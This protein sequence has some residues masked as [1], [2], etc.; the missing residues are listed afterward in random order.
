M[1]FQS[2]SQ[3]V[4]QLV[5]P[6]ATYVIACVQVHDMTC[7]EGLKSACFWARLRQLS[8]FFKQDNTQVVV[9]A[10]A[11]GCNSNGS[12]A[13]DEYHERSQRGQKLP[14]RKP[15]RSTEL[16]VPLPRQYD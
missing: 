12:S 6:S 9:E 11:L 4:P 13:A 2:R 8:L 15:A 14:T 16:G 5:R 1:S 7:T 10:I 3:Y